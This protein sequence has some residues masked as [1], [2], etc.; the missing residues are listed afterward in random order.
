MGLSTRREEAQGGKFV[1]PLAG[2]AAKKPIRP[3]LAGCAK[4]YPPR[5]AKKHALANP[6]G[7][8]IAKG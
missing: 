8:Q 5:I 1:H 2:V 4:T 7:R 6:E 3:D